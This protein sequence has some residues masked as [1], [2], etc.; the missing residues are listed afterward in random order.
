LTLTVLCHPDLSWT[1]TQ[2]ELEQIR[3]YLGEWLTTLP[4]ELL[5]RK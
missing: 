2:Q 1:A 5:M 4:A 3:E